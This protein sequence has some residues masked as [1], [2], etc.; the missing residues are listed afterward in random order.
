M[1]NGHDTRKVAVFT[2]VL[3][4]EGGYIP[5]GD[6]PQY[7]NE[8]VQGGLYDREDVQSVTLSHV[9]TT[10]VPADDQ[11]TLLADRDRLKGEV[12]DL[13][14]DVSKL[15]GTLERC[16]RMR[17]RVTAHNGELFEQLK[18]AQDLSTQCAAK[19]IENGE[20]ACQAETKARNAAYAIWCWVINANNEGGKDV[21]DLTAVLG[22]HGMPCPEG[23][24]DEG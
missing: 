13:K 16:A 4:L 18:A 23:L 5:A 2:L 14:R 10:E 8:W 22:A 7:V 20:Q 21:D 1:S 6:I 24:G 17:E 3:E 9:V 19:A 11:A 15:A 12:R